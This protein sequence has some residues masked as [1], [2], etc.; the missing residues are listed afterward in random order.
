MTW[1][2]R[3][4]IALRII[5]MASILISWYCKRPRLEFYP[6]EDEQSIFFKYKP[7]D[8]VDE[9]NSKQVYVDSDC[10]V[11][12]YVRIANK[13]HSPCTINQFTLYGDDSKPATYNGTTNVLKQYTVKI[14]DEPA[15]TQACPQGGFLYHLDRFKSVIIKKSNIIKMPYTIPPLG[16]VEGFLLFPYNT[17]RDVEKM[18]VRIDARTTRKT[19]HV[20]GT[21]Q[22]LRRYT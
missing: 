22:Q 12:Y 17:Y 21:V 9:H 2:S 11:F 15:G 16:Y 6:V 5:N 13:S 7:N 1:E 19:F 8:F 20:N 3:I 14:V 18:N 10:I 4:N